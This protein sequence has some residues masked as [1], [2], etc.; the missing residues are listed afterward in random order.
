MFPNTH[1]IGPLT[2]YMA[3][4]LGWKLRV[5]F[6]S[7]TSN[8]FYLHRGVICGGYPRATRQCFYPGR[9][10][11]MLYARESDKGRHSH[12]VASLPSQQMSSCIHPL[13]RTGRLHKRLKRCFN[14]VSDK[15]FYIQ[16]FL[17]TEAA[18]WNDMDPPFPFLMGPVTVC[19]VP[20]SNACRT[21]L[22]R[23]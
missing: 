19:F 18:A 2:P 23:R 10:G 14:L 13:W 4:K 6:I 15:I 20:L 22:S 17:G 21:S 5:S 3:P 11:L 12:K 1:Q 9:C 7:G 16:K 8:Q